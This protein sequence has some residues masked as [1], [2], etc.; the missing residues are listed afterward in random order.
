MVNP[1]DIAGKRRRRRRRKLSI[2]VDVYQEVA[3]TYF[4]FLM[5]LVQL[6]GPVSVYYNGAK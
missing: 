5:K 6:A 2:L 3:K 4:F 1:G